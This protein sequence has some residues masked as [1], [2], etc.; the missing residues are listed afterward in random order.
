M[1][2]TWFDPVCGTGEFIV[3]IYRRL[4]AANPGKEQHVIENMLYF[5]DINSNM[6]AVTCF[7][8]DP[9]NKYRKNY[10]NYDMLEEVVISKTVMY[11]KKCTRALINKKTG[12]IKYNIVHGN[13]FLHE[14]NMNFDVVVGNPPFQKENLT[15]GKNNHKI[16][17]YG[18][19]FL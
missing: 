19:N 7:R 4:L 6:T 12:E 16:I 13:R 15:K 8:L 3:Q 2:K 18:Q 10:Y 14:V 5:N 11:N 1:T 9:A 17:I